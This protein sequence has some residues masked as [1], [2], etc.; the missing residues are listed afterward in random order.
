MDP[1]QSFE[2]V[3]GQ[4]DS[5]FSY[6]E[7]SDYEPDERDLSFTEESSFHSDDSEGDWLPGE[8]SGDSFDDES[9]FSYSSDA[10][11]GCGDSTT[12]GGRHV[13]LHTPLSF[14]DWHHKDVELNT[15]PFQPKRPPGLHLPTGFQPTCEL[16]FFELFFSSDVIDSLVA[17]TN[18]YANMHI[19]QRPS[20]AKADGSWESAAKQEMS[21]FLALILSFG[22]VRIADVETYWSSE[23]FFNGL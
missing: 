20:L 11:E 3:F 21:C 23:S 1:E 5:V 6:V 15:L 16:D 2:T 18:I 17:F 10:E 7:D 4:Q 12:I 22:I 13:P 8:N 14:S 9:D 19:L